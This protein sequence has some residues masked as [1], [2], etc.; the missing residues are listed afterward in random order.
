MSSYTVT[1]TPDA[2]G[3][4]EA[5]VRLDVE[6]GTARITEFAVRPA[7]GRTIS[8]TRGSSVDFDLVLRAVGPAV[9]A[10]EAMQSVTRSSEP[11][12]AP[13]PRSARGR[14]AKS[15]AGRAG[16][17]T[18]AATRQAKPASASGGRAYRRMP[19]DVAETFAQI[20]SVTALAVHY[21]VPR[22]TAQGWVN[23]LRR[24]QAA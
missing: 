10:V 11:A 21:G 24:A 18:R 2:P 19:E 13:R 5:T 12:A 16:R 17:G 15:S 9:T 22:H 6:R 8:A 1:I 23:R 20:G 4:A 3:G 7:A 14:T